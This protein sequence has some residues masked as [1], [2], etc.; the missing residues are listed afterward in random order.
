MKTAKKC[1]KSFFFNLG[2]LFI[3]N[4]RINEMFFAVSRLKIMRPRYGAAL[5]SNKHLVEVK[6]E[7]LVTKSSAQI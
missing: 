6:T 4:N 7:L 1:G 2:H 3:K 5:A